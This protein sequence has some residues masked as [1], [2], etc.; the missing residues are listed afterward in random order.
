MKQLETEFT[1][2]QWHHRQILRE[3]NIAIYERSK[4]GNLHY[5]VIRIKSHNG[6]KLPSGEVT[7]PAE[8]YPGDNA[9]GVD[10]FTLPNSVA[11]RAKFED[12]IKSGNS[13]LET[14]KA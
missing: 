7:S 3:E 14:I 12:L 2:L 4:D 10:G 8:Y 9:W 6:F 13:K 11:A 5:E 1:R